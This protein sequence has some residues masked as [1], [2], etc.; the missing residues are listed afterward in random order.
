MTTRRVFAPLSS[1]CQQQYSCPPPPRLARTEEFSAG[2]VPSGFYKFQ[3]I[4]VLRNADI[5]G[6]P[7]E[8]CNSY[9]RSIERP[10]YLR[11]TSI[12]V[13]VSSLMCGK[14]GLFCRHEMA[15]RRSTPLPFQRM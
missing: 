7:T 15:L 4:S 11:F 8:N 3:L 5:L 2:A 13:F 14:Q 6:G 9:F 10:N 12:S 1:S